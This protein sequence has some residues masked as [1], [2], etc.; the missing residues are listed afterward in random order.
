MSSYDMTPNIN[1]APTNPK[2]HPPRACNQTSCDTYDHQANSTTQRGTLRLIRH[3]V[4][5]RTSQHGIQEHIRRVEN[6][7]QHSQLSHGFLVLVIFGTLRRVLRRTAGICQRWAARLDVMESRSRPR[8]SPRILPRC[9][10]PPTSGRAANA[11][12]PVGIA[13][14]GGTSGALSPLLIRELAPGTRR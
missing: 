4:A 2:Q 1:T 11:L 13:V 7:D 12:S 14:N 3:S 6:T 10:S 9:R 5:I 8:P